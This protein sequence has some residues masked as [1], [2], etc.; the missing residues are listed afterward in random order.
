MTKT[1]AKTGTPIDAYWS[2]PA[3]DLLAELHS[4]PDGLSTAEAQE[5]LQQVGPNVL[6]PRR[7]DTALRSFIA[8]FTSPLVLI[9]IFAAVVSAIAGEWTDAAI[10]V[11]IVVAS[12]VL[13]FAQEYTASHAVEKLRA[14]VTIKA[15]VL[16]DG[17]PQPI[18]AEAGRA[19]RHRAALGGQPDPGGRR[20][21][22]RPR[23]SSS[24]RR[25]SPARPSRWKRR[26]ARSTRTL[27]CPSGSTWCSWARTCAAAR[28]ARSSCR[29]APAPPSA[30]SPS[31]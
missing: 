2:R 14:Q 30:R 24:T 26:R 20:L 16:R 17:K 8:Q 29:P 12:A 11:V 3:A 13:S 31:G 22:W 27:G 7:R 21:C 6:K 9:L 4:A 15:T 10:V 28:R 18:P 5:R 19:R 1:P 25:C 23:T